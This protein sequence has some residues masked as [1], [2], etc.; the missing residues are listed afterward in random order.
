MPI[1]QRTN[2]YEIEP[3]H[4]H[5]HNLHNNNRKRRNNSFRVP[6]V[7]V[8]SE[9]A[10]NGDSQLIRS[11]SVGHNILLEKTSVD[12]NGLLNA[13]FNGMKAGKSDGIRSTLSQ[14][15]LLNTSSDSEHE[16]KPLRDSHKF[17]KSGTLSR[18]DI[19][20]QV[21]L[22]LKAKILWLIFRTPRCS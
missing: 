10:I 8:I 4:N 11:Q 9:Q 18:P 14:P 20:Y 19:F 15:L 6:S 17:W 12:S 1:D 22:I 21:G 13:T 3:N 2:T 5:K 7:N 16:T